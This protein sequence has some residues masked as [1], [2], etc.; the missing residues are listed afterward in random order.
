LTGENAVPSGH[1]PSWCHHEGVSCIL[2]RRAAAWKALFSPARPWAAVPGASCAL[3]HRR[4]HH[5]T[6]YLDGLVSGTG[7]SPLRYGSRMRFMS[8]ATRSIVWG[9]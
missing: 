9:S 5:S 3:P 7:Q 2:A 4:R 1:W 8:R 6:C